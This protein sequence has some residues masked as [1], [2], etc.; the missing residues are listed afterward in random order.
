MNETKS[1]LSVTGNHSKGEYNLLIER[2]EESDEGKYRCDTTNDDNAVS[3]IF[4]VTMPGI[5][6]VY[7]IFSDHCTINIGK[8]ILFKRMNMENNSHLMYIYNEHS[9]A[10][11]NCMLSV[12]P[13]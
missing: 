9:K 6:L 11:L 7:K 3:V 13:D 2:F 10:K 12:V 4:L 1:R 5:N 8:E